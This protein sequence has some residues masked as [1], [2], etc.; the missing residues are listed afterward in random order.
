MNTNTPVE[1]V[2]PTL[3]LLCGKIASGKS[4]LSARLGAAP[5]T[6]I[7]SEDTWLAALYKDEIHSVADY[8]QCASRLKNAMKPHLISLLNAGLSVVLDFPANTPAN[9]EWMMGIITASG[10]N[11]CLHYLRVSDDIC[12]ARLRARNA[13]GAHDFSAT[14]EEFEIITRYFAEPLADEGFTIIEYS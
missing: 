12:K 2:R 4:T 14:D 9:R 7:V 8:V 1:A 11:N 13:E 5:G 3:H 6:I 10:A